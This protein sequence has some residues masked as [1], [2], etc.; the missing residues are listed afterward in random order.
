MSTSPFSASAERFLSS[1]NAQMLAPCIGNQHGLYSVDPTSLFHL[2]L[3]S[4]LQ[5]SIGFATPRRAH[6]VLHGTD[7]LPDQLFRDCIARGCVKI[8]VNSW[9][10]DPQLDVWKQQ[11]ENKAGVPDMYDLGMKEYAKQVTRFLHLFGSAGKA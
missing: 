11:I 7:M 3:L 5:S 9:C 4:K 1:L 10:R 8:N 6:L 2:D